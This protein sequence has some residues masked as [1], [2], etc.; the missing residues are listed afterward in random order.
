MSALI[1]II[2]AYLKSDDG[3]L[4]ADENGDPLDDDDLLVVAQGI[5]EAVVASGWP[6][7]EP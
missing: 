5:A 1:A 4:I 7:A 3:P 6:R 2:L